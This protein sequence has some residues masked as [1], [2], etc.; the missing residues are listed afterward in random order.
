MPITMQTNIPSL[1]TQR[2]LS[3][4][5]KYLSKNFERLS[6]G[7]RINSA[8]DDA[9]GLA[10]SESMTAQIRSFLVAER[11]AGDAISMSQTAEG[12][13]GEMSSILTRMREL[14]IQS[15]NGSNTTTDRSFLQTEFSQLQEELSRIQD[16]VKFN[17]R[18]L[19]ATATSNITFQ[20]GLDNVASDQITLTFGGVDLATLQAQSVGGADETAAQD[21][22][23]VIDSS[24]SAINTS[25][26]R[27][28]AAMNRMDVTISSM[29]TMRLNLSAANS[30]IRDVDVAEETAQMSK[31]QILS[32]SGVAILA[33]AN[34][35][36]ALALSL[37]Q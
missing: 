4:S 28:G 7:L 31:N 19:L 29:Q 2:H 27:F 26:A 5:Q 3:K 32:Q 8:A 34:Q 37:L 23:A 13:L 17:G 36:P 12:S 24:L 18:P 30:R 20:V 16:S 6:S 25:R 1:L 11:N 35:L 10:I 22:L 9:A 15:A 21:S 33:Q 14:A